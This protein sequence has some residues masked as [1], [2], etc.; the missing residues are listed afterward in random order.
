MV[1]K[2]GIKPC[3]KDVNIWSRQEV[4]F[5]CGM[6]LMDLKSYKVMEDVIPVAKKGPVL[7]EVGLGK[8]CANANHLTTT[9]TSLGDIGHVDG[10]EIGGELITPCQIY[11]SRIKLFLS[12]WHTNPDWL[13]QQGDL[14]FCP[15]EIFIGQVWD[16]INSNLL[17]MGS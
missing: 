15:I 16:L 5:N 17:P 3:E 6:S 14:A 4:G 7:N 9:P 2:E 11:G 1:N 12:S 10:L 13:E 8:T